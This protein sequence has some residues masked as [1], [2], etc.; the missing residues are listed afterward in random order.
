MVVVRLVLFE[1]LVSIGIFS[2]GGLD[3]ARRFDNCSH[4][5]RLRCMDYPVGSG[6]QRATVVE[7]RLKYKGRNEFLIFDF[8]LSRNHEGTQMDTKDGVRLAKSQ[9]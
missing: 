9:N 1:R 7:E 2:K 6:H 3:T 8:K 4:C 5:D